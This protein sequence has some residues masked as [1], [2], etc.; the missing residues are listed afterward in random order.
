[1]DHDDIE[2]AASRARRALRPIGSPADLDE[3]ISAY[4]TDLLAEAWRPDD[5]FREAAGR[6]D[7]ASGF[8]HHNIRVDPPSG[9]VIV[10]IPIPA[11]DVMDLTIWPEPAVLRALRGYVRHAPLLLHAHDAPPYQVHGYI[12]GDLLDE[13][14][15]R[16]DAVPG[17]VI[18]DVLA[19]FDELGRVPRD[20]LPAPPPDWPAD[21]DTPG[22]APRLSALTVGVHRRFAAEFGSLFA[23]LGMPADPF[24][25]IDAG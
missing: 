8:Y 3:R 25:S 16:G 14:A 5:L 23:D 24:A 19:L 11:S 1:V 18:G 13:I 21:Q 2:A 10:R 12:E 15:P 20:R 4:V 22:F 7:A 17:H 6:A 9:P